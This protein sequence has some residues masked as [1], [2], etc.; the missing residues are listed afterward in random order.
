MLEFR[1]GNHS[2]AVLRIPT[3]VGVP[4]ARPGTQLSCL[5]P[6]TN[7]IRHCVIL[8]QA[9][10]FFQVFPIAPELAKGSAVILAVS[11]LC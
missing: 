1:V 2:A 5:A 10:S 9:E 11:S 4:H 7:E 8:R 3:E 6:M